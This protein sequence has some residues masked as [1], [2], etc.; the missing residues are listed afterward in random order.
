MLFQHHKI[1]IKRF[2]PVPSRRASSSLPLDL[3]DLAFKPLSIFGSFFSCSA[4]HDIKCA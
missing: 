3:V 1:G 4:K 2:F